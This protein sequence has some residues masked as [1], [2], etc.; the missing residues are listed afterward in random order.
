MS[1]HH[2]CRAAGPSLLFRTH[3]EARAL[4]TRL[5]REVPAPMALCLMPDH[6]H[7]LHER[8]VRAQFGHALRSYALWRNAHRGGSGPVFGEQP[9]AEP[10]PGAVKE[11]RT[12]RYIHL[13]P[14]RAGLVSDP[15]AWPWSTHRDKVALARPVLLAPHPRPHDFHRYVSGDPT[16][17]IE[18]TLLPVADL[19]LGA[20][21][22]DAIAAAVTELLRVP[23][24]SLSRRGPARTLWVRALRS[25]TDI[26]ASVVARHVGLTSQAVRR[27]PARSTPTTR[28]VARLAL[29]PRFPGLLD[30]D[31][32]HTGTWHHYRHRP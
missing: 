29:D 32:R 30:G 26:P 28:L 19:G 8:K 22:V 15:L 3:L 25:L 14:C 20:D 4:W 1:H 27:V 7:L 10:V 6:V 5:L 17:A 11:R 13:N 16:V 24:G 21:H 23:F 31:L 9:P 18:G 2:V 12:V